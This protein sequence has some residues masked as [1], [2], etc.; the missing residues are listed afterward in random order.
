MDAWQEAAAPLACGNGLTLRSA[1]RREHHEARKVLGV[2]AE[3]V[4]GPRTHRRSSRHAKARVHQRV[5]R[6]VVDLLGHHRAHDADVVRDA[7]DMRQQRRHV[8]SG[9]AVT[10]ERML[11]RQNL[12]LLALELGDLLSLGDRLGHGLAVELLQHRFVVEQLQM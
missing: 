9:L 10:L 3:S 4:N 6:I 12:Q 5:R 7:A 2:A 1:L 11:R 8:L